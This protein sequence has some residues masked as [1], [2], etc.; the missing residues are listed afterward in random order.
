MDSITC[1]TLT[2][3]NSFIALKKKSQWNTHLKKEAC[4]LQSSNSLRAQARVRA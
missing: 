1:P 2:E 4:N 3:E